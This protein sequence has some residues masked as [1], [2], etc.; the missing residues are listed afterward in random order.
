MALQSWKKNHCEQHLDEILQDITY[1]IENEWDDIQYVPM[2][3][4]YLNQARWEGR[5][6]VE[7]FRKLKSEIHNQKRESE[8]NNRQRVL[9]ACRARRMQQEGVIDLPEDQ[10][11]VVSSSGVAQQQHF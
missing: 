6:D 8:E 2:A 3:T 10:Y 11:R 7:G 5:T 4:T 1:K 9:A